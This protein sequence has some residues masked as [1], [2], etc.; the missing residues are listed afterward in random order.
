MED[1]KIGK[2]IRSQ[3]LS[4]GMTRVEVASKMGV[5][6]GAIR[7]WEKK[8]LDNTKIG[9]AKKLA[10]ILNIDPLILLEIIPIPEE[11][12]LS[13]KVKTI[14]RKLNNMPDEKVDTVDNFLDFISD[15]ENNEI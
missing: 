5:T 14:A 6:E 15:K 12:T 11:Y 13:N 1:N 10:E 7:V 2:L 3:I 4:L 8:G 9:T